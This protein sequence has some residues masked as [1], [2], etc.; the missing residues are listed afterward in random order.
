MEKLINFCFENNIVNAPAPINIK[1]V[2]IPHNTFEM[3]LALTAFNVVI[4]LSIIAP[5]INTKSMVFP[6]SLNKLFSNHRLSSAHVISGTD[7]DI[8]ILEF[9]LRLLTVK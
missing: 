2:I 9:F 8:C 1:P 4:M 7:H 3:R 6:V 5:A